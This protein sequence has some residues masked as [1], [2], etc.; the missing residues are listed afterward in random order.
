MSYTTRAFKYT[1]QLRDNA[2]ERRKLEHRLQ[3][4]AERDEMAEREFQHLRK[5]IESDEPS[6]EHV[7][8]QAKVPGAPASAVVTDAVEAAVRQR[9]GRHRV[10][11]ARAANQH[12]DFEQLC[13]RKILEEVDPPKGPVMESVV[14]EVARRLNLNDPDVQV[15]A[16]VERRA[17]QLGSSRARR[18]NPVG[19]EPE[20]ECSMCGNILVIDGTTLRGIHEQVQTS[21]AGLE[22]V[23]LHSL[24]LLVQAGIVAPHEDADDGLPRFMLTKKGQSLLTGLLNAYQMGSGYTVAPRYNPAADG[25]ELDI[26][27]V[28]RDSMTGLDKIHASVLSEPV[29]TS[30]EL[31]ERLKMD[32]ELVQ[33]ALKTLK[34][35]GRIYFDKKQKLYYGLAVTVDADGQKEKP[36]V[37]IIRSCDAVNRV[38]PTLVDAAYASVLHH[39]VKSATAL[40]MRGGEDTELVKAA[41]TILQCEGRVYFD[42]AARNFKAVENRSSSLFEDPAGIRQRVYEAVCVRPTTLKGL[43]FKL[44][45]PDKQVLIALQELEAAESVV[46]NPKGVQW[47]QTVGDKRRNLKSG[48]APTW[49]KGCMRRTSTGELAEVGQA[50]AQGSADQPPLP[51]TKKKAAAPP[52]TLATYLVQLKDK[53]TIMGR[54]Y[55]QLYQQPMGTLESLATSLH[56]LPKQVSSALWYLKKEGV[57]CQLLPS[58]RWGRTA[59]AKQAH[60]NPEATSHAV[61]ELN[62]FRV[63]SILKTRP[64]TKRQ[65]C[66][67]LDLA[68][69]KVARAIQVLQS[70]NEIRYNKAAQ[71]WEAVKSQAK[72]RPA[73]PPPPPPT[74]ASHA[75]RVTQREG[76]PTIISRVYDQLLFQTKGTTE[77]L[78]TSLKLKPKQVA[79][80]L[81]TLARRG[82]VE[83][84]LPSKRWER[85]LVDKRANPKPIMRKGQPTIIARVAAQLKEFDQPMPAQAF[86]DALGLKLSQVT[87]ALKALRDRGKA[88][89]AK[90]GWKRR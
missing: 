61:A 27:F 59:A 50:P 13:V 1:C 33:S 52:T 58:K 5:R 42:E 19:I 21:G 15:R 25:G 90:R 20:V 12:L 35:Q 48:E 82:V 46:R 10:Q 56:L 39:P 8:K 87:T 2:E 36:S 11:A 65:L 40:A 77:S 22:H 73:E 78:A 26:N 81:Q 60:P 9:V 34:Q 37:V 4:L 57:A 31:A 66:D 86:A 45:L 17:Q 76:K 41:L 44:G 53:P 71:Q 18:N 88:L 79:G 62:V 84:K 38:S 6:S 54:V 29:R 55:K 47:W 72:Q 70:R 89:N 75:V 64:R 83:R 32:H 80:A 16:E 51:T 30:A 7:L 23:E 3:I 49:T 43:A 68:H 67:T 14:S 69:T 28:K 85:T 63:H 24:L 74:P